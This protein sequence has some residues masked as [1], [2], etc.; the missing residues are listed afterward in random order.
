MFNDNIKQ[1]VKIIA[2]EDVAEK[3]V[4]KTKKDTWSKKKLYSIIAPDFLGGKPVAETFS[5]KDKDVVGRVVV[6]PFSEFTGN[7]KDFKVKIK[8]RV[9]EIKGNEAHTEY[10]GQELLRDQVLRTIRRWSSRIDSVDDV[11]LS[12]SSTF[13]VKSLTVSARRVNTAIKG[14]IRHSVSS[15][16]KEYLATKTTDQMVEDVNTSKLQSTVEGK[17]RKVYP[18]RNVEIRM[19]QKI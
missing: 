6:L 8:L 3:K 15:F 17:A 19:I 1:T 14:E 9:T 10:A 11:K 7:Y 16:I 18:V 5:L 4:S 2:K 12:D 13:R